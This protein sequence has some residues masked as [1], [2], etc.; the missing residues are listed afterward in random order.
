MKTIKY[1]LILILLNISIFANVTLKAP[2][3]FIKGEP[4]IFEYEAVGS[5]IEFPEIKSIDGYLVESIG[6]SRSLQIIN[7]NYDE[8]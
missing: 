7:G 6:T 5:S 4:F 1:F 3:S 2:N 8:K